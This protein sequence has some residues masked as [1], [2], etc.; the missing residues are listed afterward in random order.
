MSSE[1]IGQMGSNKDRQSIKH[2]VG[3]NKEKKTLK[4]KT[5]NH[6]YKLNAYKK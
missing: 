5:Q 3:Q 2:R 4:C 6:L 1:A